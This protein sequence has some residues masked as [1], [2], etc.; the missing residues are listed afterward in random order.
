MKKYLCFLL[1][2]VL[3]PFKARDRAVHVAGVHLFV[4]HRPQRG[5]GNIV[6]HQANDD[7]PD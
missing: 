5:R 6:P 3:G 2:L 7:L 1:V 4:A